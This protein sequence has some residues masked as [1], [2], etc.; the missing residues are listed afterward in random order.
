MGS[1]PLLDAVVVNYQTPDDLEGFLASW[2]AFAPPE[3]HLTI[4][5]VCPT[6]RDDA[7][8]EASTADRI[9]RSDK[10]IGYARA[11]NFA[12][13]GGRSEYLAF[14]NADTRIRPGVLF[15]CLL[16]FQADPT[17]AIIGPKQVDEAGRITHGGIFG[18]LNH[19]EHRG[20]MAQDNDNFSDVREAVSV[21]GS[22]YFIR[23]SVWDELTHCP[24]YREVAPYARGAFLPTR[25][26]YEETFCSYH[27]QAHGHKVIY[28]GA[29]RMIHKWHRASPVGGEVD[30]TMGEARQYFREACDHHGINHD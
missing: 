3:S 20:W 24:L 11:C 16:A 13:Q 5:N 1:N 14:F 18:T 10:N 7:I 27:A 21:S 6:D 2:Q 19:P 30:A 15:Q 9:H 8:A 22:A 17:W 28:F 26:Y 4:F 23:R 12:A 25:H 29:A